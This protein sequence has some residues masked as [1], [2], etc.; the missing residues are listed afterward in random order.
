MNNFSEADRI[1]QFEKLM[2]PYVSKEFRNWLIA[3]GFFTAPASIQ[4]HGAYTGALFDHSF[5]VTKNASFLH[6]TAWVIVDERAQPL[7]CGYV[8]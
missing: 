8:P 3:N 6:R 4:H 2:N 5:A 1:E 7:Y